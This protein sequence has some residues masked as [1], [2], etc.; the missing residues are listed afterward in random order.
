MIS[1]SLPR[2]I[3]LLKCNREKVAAN[4]ISR[5]QVPGSHVLF[6]PHREIKGL[7]SQPFDIPV[8]FS[9]TSKTLLPLRGIGISNVAAL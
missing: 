8:G 7:V 9:D 6:L 3:A 1:R 5:Q 2:L 4:I